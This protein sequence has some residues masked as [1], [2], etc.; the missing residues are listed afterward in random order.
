M[1]MRYFGFERDPFGV[2]PDPRDLYLSP[3]H[4]E[5]LASLIY[6]FNSNRGFTS[7]IAQPGMGKTT[8]LYSFLGTIRD[9]ARIVFLFDTQCGPI[10]LLRYILYDLGMEPGPDSVEMHRQL[11]AVVAE[12]ARRGRKLAIVLDEAQNLSEEALESVRLLSNLET[13]QGKLVHV[14]LAGQPELACTLDSPSMVQLRQRIATTSRIDPLSAEEGA[15]YIAHRIAASGYSGAPLFTSEAVRMIVESAGGIPRVINNLSFNALSICCALKRGC[16]D[17]A[18]ASEAIGDMRIEKPA[19][20]RHLEMRRKPALAGRVRADRWVAAA[21]LIALAGS[22]V[23]RFALFSNHADSGNRSTVETFPKLTLSRKVPQPSAAP[24]AAK[25]K[26]VRVSSREREPS[27]E[28]LLHELESVNL[29][30]TEPNIVPS[31]DRGRIPLNQ[32]TPLANEP[33]LSDNARHIHEP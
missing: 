16:V 3:S 30:P 11:H 33:D 13:P 12:E 32:G 28:R 17:R 15:R 27:D 5:A 9:S 22:G 6:G 8:L 14:V 29:G 10:D 4:G 25:L 23:S 26:H 2:T 19:D 18:I 1:L 24:V 31:G 7:L 21:A 20:H